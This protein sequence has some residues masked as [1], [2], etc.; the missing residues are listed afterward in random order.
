VKAFRFPL[1]TVLRL[2]ESIEQR[3]ERALQKIQLE[4]ARVSHQIEQVTTH[5]AEAQAAREQALRQQIP[6][7][8][9]QTML[10]GAQAAIAKKDALLETLHALEQQ[11]I[12]QLNVY[13][14][15]HRDHETLLNMA[16]EQ[17]SAY[18]LHQARVEQKFLD[19]V[20]MARRHQSE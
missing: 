9:L 3:E 19:D 13:Q 16:A 2:R 7:V 6:A 17:R 12:Q 15:A 1:A 20:F 10:W 5:I 4:M 8:E 18:E 11:R 14:A